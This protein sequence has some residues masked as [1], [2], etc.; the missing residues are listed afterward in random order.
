MP[1]A[2]RRAGRKIPLKVGKQIGCQQRINCETETGVTISNQDATFG[3]DCFSQYLIR[4]KNEMIVACGRQGLG[5]GTG[6]NPD[7]VYQQ[8]VICKK[9]GH[10]GKEQIG[11]GFLPRPTRT[12]AG[13]G[14]RNDDR[15]GDLGPSPP[16]QPSPASRGRGKGLCEFIPIQVFVASRG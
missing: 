12:S 14:F 13:V 16:S 2:K 5:L 1:V 11:T 4:V 10:F 6:S 3:T 8:K 7:P 9:S 15:G